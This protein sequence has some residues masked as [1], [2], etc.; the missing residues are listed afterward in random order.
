KM[1]INKKLL[2][3][4]SVLL[5]ILQARCSDDLVAPT[6]AP[7]E[8]VNK[9][10]TTIDTIPDATTIQPDISDESKHQ[11]RSDTAE[12]DSGR[13]ENESIDSNSTPSDVIPL[14]FDRKLDTN[15]SDETSSE[16]DDLQHGGDFDK[17]LK[18]IHEDDVIILPV[19]IDN[20]QQG[21][22]SNIEWIEED[23]EEVDKDTPPLVQA[24]V[25]KSLEDDYRIQG[26][27]GI[28]VALFLIV[29]LV[30]GYVGFVVWRRFIEKRYGNREILINE[31]DMVDPSDMKH[32]SL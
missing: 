18:T 29:F 8:I 11:P 17:I 27:M 21:P 15:I 32:F 13:N 30:A 2:C 10:P 7:S 28:I 31:E 22:T 12:A 24:M 5:L 25:D 23:E 20:D 9:L 3:Y 4:L 16:F 6:A 19:P 14:E 1:E 26:Q